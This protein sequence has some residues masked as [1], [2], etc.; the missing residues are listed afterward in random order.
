MRIFV[1]VREIEE[2]E[3]GRPVAAVPG[4]AL[5]IPLGTLSDRWFE[6]PPVQ[7]MDNWTWIVRDGAQAR[8]LAAAIQ[9][10]FDGLPPYPVHVLTWE[11]ASKGDVAS[12]PFRPLPLWRPSPVLASVV[13]S[14][15]AILAA[16]GVPQVTSL[17]KVCFSH[18]H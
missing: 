16:Q 8:E 14:L 13:E 3:K 9:A 1:D 2:F 12:G 17:R 7:D 11:E 4:H 6:L 15:E 5:C 10:R 18:C